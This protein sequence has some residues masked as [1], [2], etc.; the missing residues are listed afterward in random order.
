[1]ALNSIIRLYSNWSISLAANANGRWKG[2]TQGEERP[3]QGHGQC[4]DVCHCVVQDLECSRRGLLVVVLVVLNSL[5]KFIKMVRPIVRYAV[6][7]LGYPTFGLCVPF[8]LVDSETDFWMS[9]S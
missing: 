4:R 1:M 6:E 9:F 2:N 7:Q 5:L 8:E 3:H